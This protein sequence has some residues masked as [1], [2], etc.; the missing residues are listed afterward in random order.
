[1]R[2]GV[3]GFKNV[4]F[5]RLGKRTLLRASHAPRGRG[6]APGNSSLREACR[7]QVVGSDTLCAQES[8]RAQP[9]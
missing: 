9:P 3:G 6:N 8:L 2:G 4:I 1:M 7:R 5:V